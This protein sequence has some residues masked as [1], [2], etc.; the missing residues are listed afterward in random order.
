M[1][2][3]AQ[4]LMLLISAALWAYKVRQSGGHHRGKG[5]QWYCGRKPLAAP[6]AGDELGDEG[7][8]AG[9]ERDEGKN[10]DD[11]RAG[12]HEVRKRRGDREVPEPKQGR[13]EAYPWSDGRKRMKT[14][15]PQH[16]PLFR[17]PRRVSRPA[18]ILQ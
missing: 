9:Q 7:G 3:I 6:P 16:Y 15:F 12:R 5:L 1:E 10:K 17:P 14:E 4:G 2:R 11:E 18:E 13:E 8:D